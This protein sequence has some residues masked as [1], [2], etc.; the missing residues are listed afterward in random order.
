MNLSEPSLEIPVEQKIS[1]ARD[2]FQRRKQDLLGDAKLTEIFRMLK[3]AVIQSQDE[4]VQLGIGEVCKTCEEKEGGCC[5]GTGIEKHYSASLL[6]LNL[7]LGAELPASRKDSLSCVF[8]SEKGCR[9]LARHVIC[10]NYLCHRI[11]SR[12]SAQELAALREKE[13]LELSLVFS[14]H[15][16]IK[17]KLAT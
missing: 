3:Q 5:C 17:K 4:R 6:L 12:F 15:E 2:A 7:L 8:L 10:V 11:T 14:T 9:L 1:W 16:M 13:G